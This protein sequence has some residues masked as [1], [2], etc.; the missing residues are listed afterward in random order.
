MRSK[1]FVPAS[2]PELFAKALASAADAISFDLEDAVAPARKQEARTALSNFLREHAHQPHGKTLIVRVNQVNSRN[3]GEDVAAVT[4]PG[5]ALINVPKPFGPDAVNIAGAQ[6]EA[7]ERE[8]GYFDK[9]KQPTKLLVNIETPD[10]LLGAAR[11][12]L[13]HPRV[14]GLQL[15]LADLF[16]PLGMHRRER[17]AIEQAM[18]T[19]R[20]AAGAAGVFAYDAAFANTQDADGFRAEAELAYRMGFIGKSCIHPSQIALANAVFRPSD[21]EIA[22]A[23]RVLTAMREAQARGVA[24]YLVD[25][26]MIDPPF[27]RRAEAIVATA[28][29]LGL[30]AA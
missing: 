27:E 30:I 20:M 3:F 4:M 13:A 2:R 9:A 6:I 8:Y 15:G 21:D 23:Q 26:K 10:A 16:E 5:V 14:A 22:E 25:G 18:F 1:L 24:A 29:R 19:V 12:A 11:L 17:A 7:M 28:Q